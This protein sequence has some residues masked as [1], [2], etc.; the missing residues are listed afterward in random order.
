MPMLDPMADAIRAGPAAIN[1][2]WQL[3]PMQNPHG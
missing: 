2:A 3:L 1:G